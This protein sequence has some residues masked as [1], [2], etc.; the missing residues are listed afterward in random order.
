MEF[1]NYSQ[2][3]F[4]FLDVGAQQMEK[5]KQ[6]KN[7]AGFEQESWEMFSDTSPNSHH[8]EEDVKLVCVVSERQRINE[9]ELQEKQI[10]AQNQNSLVI[11][12]VQNLASCF[13]S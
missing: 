2:I 9:W 7:N 13:K 3:S 6:T 12:A 10:L 1:A 11:T 4:F 5:K 8:V